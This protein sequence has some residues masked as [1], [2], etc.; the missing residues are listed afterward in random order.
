MSDDYD[1]DPPTDPAAD[2]RHQTRRSVPSVVPVPPDRSDAIVEVAAP[3]VAAIAP[4]PSAEGALLAAVL[5]A[6]RSEVRTEI[7]HELGGLRAEWAADIKGLKGQMEEGTNRQLDAHEA[8]RRHVVR[9]STM[10]QELWKEVFG[11]KPPPPPPTKDKT[12]SFALSESDPDIVAAAK[13]TGKNARMRDKVESQEGT[14]AALHG[15]MLAM[16]GRQERFET[17]LCAVKTEVQEVKTVSTETLTLQK[18]QMGK[19]DPAQDKRGIF[20]RIADAMLYAVREREG[21][22]FVL[23]FL[24]GLTGLLSVAATLYALITGRPPPLLVMPPA[25]IPAATLPSAPAHGEP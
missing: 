5:H 13:Q 15:Q 16:D 12:L 4:P 9:V 19:K 1:E 6:V 14:L 20:T 7:R 11:D 17:E 18:E 8:T 23:I 25:P 10:T 24:S 22:K 21:Q 2:P 3:Q